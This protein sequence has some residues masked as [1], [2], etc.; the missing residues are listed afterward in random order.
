MGDRA[1]VA[2]KTGA[3]DFEH[4]WMYTHN[5]G[6]GLPDRLQSALSS[7]TARGRWNDESYLCR[8]LLD[9]MLTDHESGT[10]YGISHGIQ[11]NEYDILEVDIPA[12]V[13]RIRPFNH[14]AWR[15]DWSAP[16]LFEMGF[17][18]FCELDEFHWESRTT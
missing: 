17:K 10:G 4:V 14:K 6:Y 8:I 18:E 3:G 12:Q 13:V 15:V 16:P 5:A 11:D 1:N 9:R 7:D 2:I